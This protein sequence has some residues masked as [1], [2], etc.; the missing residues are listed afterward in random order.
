MDAH[1]GYGFAEEYDI[2]RKFRESR[3]YRA[4]PINNNLVLA[5]V[6]EHVLGMPRSY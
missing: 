6:G 1:G 4:A 3:L 5:Y 2:E